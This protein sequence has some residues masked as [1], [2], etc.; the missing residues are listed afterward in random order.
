[1]FV[2]CMQMLSSQSLHSVPDSTTRAHEQKYIVI[3]VAEGLNQMKEKKES[4]R[5]FNKIQH[6]LQT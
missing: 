1:M 6:T 5:L 4:C 2:S 3:S